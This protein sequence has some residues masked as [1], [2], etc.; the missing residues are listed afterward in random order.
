MVQLLEKSNRL[1]TF[2]DKGVA[3][4]LRSVTCGN[5]GQAGHYHQTCQGQ[6]ANCGLSP[7]CAHL[8]LWYSYSMI[9]ILSVYGNTNFTSAPAYFHRSDP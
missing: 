5:C 1:K 9:C 3:R 8:G 4:Q 6:C 7:Q 2:A